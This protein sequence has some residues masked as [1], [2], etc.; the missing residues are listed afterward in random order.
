MQ[1]ISEN[2]EENRTVFHKTVHSSAATTSGHP[3]SKHQ[4][5][6]DENDDEIQR[7]LEEKHRLRKAHRD[8]T[9]SKKAA[10]SNICKTVH[11][12]LRDLRDSWLRKKTEEIQF[13]LWTERT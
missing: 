1:S 8:D 4:D 11:T 2:P 7:L 10:Y 3:S 13:F 9:S 5:W 6:F 12:K